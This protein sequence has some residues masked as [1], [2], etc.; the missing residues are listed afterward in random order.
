MQPAAQPN[1]FE[2]L[3]PIIIIFAVFY[4][5]II[6]PQSKKQKDH[7][8][9]L[10]SL[11]RGDEVITAS[12]IL[13]TIDGLTDLYVTLEVANNV[14]IKVLRSQIASLAKNLNPSTTEKKG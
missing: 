1:L 9:F 4:F 8:S 13:G 7:L 3:L 2:S 12:G 11:K 6:R 10:N 5:L 14:K